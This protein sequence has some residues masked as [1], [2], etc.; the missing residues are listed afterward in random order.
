MTAA[1]DA[2]D[3]VILPDAP[4][5]AGLRFRRF[6]G[7]ADDAPMVAVVNAAKAADGSAERMTVEEQAGRYSDLKNCDPAQDMLMVEFDGALVA[8]SRVTWW[9]EATAPEPGADS[10]GVPRIYYHLQRL[11]PARRGQGIEAALLNWAEARL[12]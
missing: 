1:D 4:A 9:D 6:R 3:A 8:Y 2:D 12:R 11:D 7:V 5:I 10:P